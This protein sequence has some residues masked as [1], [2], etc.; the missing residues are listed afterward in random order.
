MEQWKEVSGYEGYYEVSNLGRVRT[1]ERIV[2]G[3]LAPMRMKP[4][5][6]K[7]GLNSNG[8][9]AVEFCKN[10]KQKKYS[11]HRLVAEAFIPKIEGKNLINHKNGIKTDN[12]VENLEWCTSQE[13]IRHAFDSGLKVGV[14]GERHGQ[15][16][17]TVTQVHELR[18]MIE[19][20]LSQRKI[21]KH[22]GITQAAVSLINKG[23][24]W[25]HI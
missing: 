22:F 11:V 13:N 20:G 19:S 12:R 3:K 18:S 9:P 24:N 25:N 5:Y 10:G 4:I 6:L 1:I 15:S 21:A 2:Q 8:Y 14:N 23:K 7:C 17:L 16:K